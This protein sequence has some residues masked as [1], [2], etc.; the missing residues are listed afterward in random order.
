MDPRVIDLKECRLW[1]EECAVELAR[2][3]AE[4]AESVMPM[5]PV[6]CVWLTGNRLTR[7]PDAVLGM[8]QLE[9]LYLGRNRIAVVPRELGRLTRL[10][11]LGLSNNPLRH[12]PT[13]LTNLKNLSSLYLSATFDSDMDACEVSADLL[14][15]QDR[16]PRGVYHWMEALQRYN[17]SVDRCRHAVI[18]LLAARRHPSTPFMR[19]V[20]REL[21]Q[22]MARHVW[23]S[24]HERVVWV[25]EESTG[26]V[27]RPSHATLLQLAYRLATRVGGGA[28]RETY[29]EELKSFFGRL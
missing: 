23:A 27:N 3:L 6:T 17:A 25:P 20:P 15:H 4:R 28:D 21:V 24:R 18:T 1:D 2:L 13:E 29:F 11:S 14:T 5:P 8:T 12:L 9:S 10:A 22:L 19:A 16:N 7:V 26:D